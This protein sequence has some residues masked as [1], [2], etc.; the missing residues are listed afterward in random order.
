M[1]WA[2]IFPVAVLVLAGALWLSR[3][4]DKPTGP[5]DLTPKHRERLERDFSIEMASL[6]GRR[7]SPFNR[8]KAGRDE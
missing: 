1:T 8:F 4:R 3:K 6:L 2:L 5:D 7:E